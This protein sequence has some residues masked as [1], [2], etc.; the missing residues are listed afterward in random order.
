[1]P[2]QRNILFFK[3]IEAIR[4]NMNIYV[5]RDRERENTKTKVKRTKEHNLIGSLSHFI[6]IIYK[7]KILYLKKK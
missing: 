4:K 2:V 7:E 1:M 3:L 6:V 5:Y